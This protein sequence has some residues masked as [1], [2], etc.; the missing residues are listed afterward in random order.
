MGCDAASSKIVNT[1]GE[2]KSFIVG[3]IGGTNLRLAMISGNKMMHSKY[4]VT[5]EHP[6]LITAIK[7]FVQEYNI[8]GIQGC[9]LAMAG[10]VDGDACTLTNENQAYQY[11]AKEFAAKL[12]YDTIFINDFQAIGWWIISRFVSPE[13]IKVIVNND[14]HTGAKLYLGAGTGLGVGYVIGSKVYPCEGGHLR[15]S[16]ACEIEFELVEFLKTKLCIQHVS[17]ERLV[18][19]SGIAFIAEFFLQKSMQELHDYVGFGPSDGAVSDFLALPDD[20]YERPAYVSVQSKHNEAAMMIM[21]IFFNF[22]GRAISDLCVAMLPSEIFIAGGIMAK[23]IHLVEQK[24]VCRMFMEG[25]NDKG[26][27]SH[28]VTNRKISVIMEENIGLFGCAEC[29]MKFE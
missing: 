4:F 8:T 3:D 17:Y 10:P 14:V 29:I 16:P 5:R 15:F 12:G 21:G 11:S 7:L 28:V 9:C 2:K 24:D 13:S 20:V 1:I 23:N 19:G 27:L 26:R 18:S 22:Y 6:T 25:L